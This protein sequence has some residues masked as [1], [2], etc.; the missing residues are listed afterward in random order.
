MILTGQEHSHLKANLSILG[1]GEMT[2]ATF[3]ARG[4]KVGAAIESV[5]QESCAHYRAKEKAESDRADCNWDA[6]ISV[7]YDGAWQKHGKA[8]D[9]ITG[10]GKVIGEY[11]GKVHDYVIK[12]TR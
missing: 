8:Q 11:T 9:S 12:T 6:L 4:R 10:F 3:N 5:C 1:F 7:V 2:S